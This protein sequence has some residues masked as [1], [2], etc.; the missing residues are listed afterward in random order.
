MTEASPPLYLCAK[1]PR[2][3]YPNA[4]QTVRPHV[5]VLNAIFFR[6]PRLLLG[7]L[8]ECAGHLLT[9]RQDPYEWLDDFFAAC[10]GIEGGC[11]VTAIAVHSYTCE[12]RNCTC[13]QCCSVVL[14][15]HHL[16][17]IGEAKGVEHYHRVVFRYISYVVFSLPCVLA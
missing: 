2:S 10:N 1:S 9:A 5:F 8:A 11:G 4:A 12:V 16:A 6:S 15:V 13:K 14:L 3:L 7:A 17:F